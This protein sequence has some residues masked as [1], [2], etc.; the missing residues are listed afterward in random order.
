MASNAALESIRRPQIIDAA[1]KSIAESGFQNVTL[2]D[3]AKAAGL[4][5]GGLVYYFPTKDSLIKQAVVEFYNQ[6]FERGRETRDRLSDPLEQVLSFTWIYDL[7]DPDVR[8]GYRLLFDFMAL[9]SQDDDY[10]RLFHDWFE[11]WIALLE[12]PILE[13]IRAGSFKVKDVPGT[14][15]TVSAIYQGIATR[16]YLDR[17]THSTEWAVKSVRRAV[18][19]LLT[20]EE[21]E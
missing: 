19:L 7:Q 6:I 13:G 21:N 11:N 1:L 3:V 2:D 10:R 5:K 14:A 20:T 8:V 9:A 15:R 18:T 12:A 4:S 17:E 16:W